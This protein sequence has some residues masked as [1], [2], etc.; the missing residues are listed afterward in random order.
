MDTPGLG[1]GTTLTFLTTGVSLQVRKISDS[2]PSREAKDTSHLGTT[3][4]SAGEYANR[5]Y[6]PGKLKDPGELTL[7]VFYDSDVQLE[8]IE[9]AA[10]TVRITYP[11]GD[12]ESTASKDEGSAFVTNVSYDIDPDEVSVAS[13]T[14]K[15]SG[16]WDFTAAT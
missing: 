15:K 14:L 6:I 1:L 7:E 9:D 13:I 16:V 10:E 2:G 8:M 12:G 5:T 3:E 4:A 11:L